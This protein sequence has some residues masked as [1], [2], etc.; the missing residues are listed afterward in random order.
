MMHLNESLVHQNIPEILE[1]GLCHHAHR[2]SLERGETNFEISERAILL[3]ATPILSVSRKQKATAQ[4]TCESEL[5]AGGI[6]TMAG[7]NTGQVSRG[8]AIVVP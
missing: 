4:S 1:F 2:G 5:Y 7:V 6:A 8:D 3:N